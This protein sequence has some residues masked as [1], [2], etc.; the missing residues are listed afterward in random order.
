[1]ASKIY[2]DPEIGQIELNKSMRCRRIG[3]RVHPL[4]GVRVSIPYYS[5]YQSGIDFFF[6][7]KEWVLENLKRFQKRL[8]EYTQQ[9]LDIDPK[10]KSEA[11]RQANEVLPKRTAYLAQKFGLKYNRVS[12]KDNKT[13]WGSCSTLGNINLNFRLILLEEH[14]C[15]YI[16]LHELAHLT[17]PNHGR[18][19]HILLEKYCREHIIELISHGSQ[20]NHDLLLKMRRSRSEFPVHKTMHGEV[21]KTPLLSLVV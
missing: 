18:S 3:I 9:Q 19:F 1:M 13:N 17:V 8:D 4:N 5:S 6:K 7:K 2:N 14:L 15:D 10:Q 11:I 12:I 16:I 20:A 21:R